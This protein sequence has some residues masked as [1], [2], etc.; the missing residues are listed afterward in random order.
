MRKK[1]LLLA[2]AYFDAST[3]YRTASIVPG[4]QI[5]RRLLEGS[6]VMKGNNYECILFDDGLIDLVYVWMLQRCICSCPSRAEVGSK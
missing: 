1:T 2:D 5:L 3:S 4:I 6:L